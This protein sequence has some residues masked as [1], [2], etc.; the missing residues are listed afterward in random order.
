MSKSSITTKPPIHPGAILAEDLADAAISINE[1]A[2]SLRV[3]TNRLSRIIRGERGVTA[4]TALRLAAF[5]GT[6]ARY[7]M[8]LQALYELDVAQRMNPAIASDV[9]PLGRAS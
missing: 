5:W 7:W 3:P 1:L 9:L 2:R 8:N 6:S 4:D